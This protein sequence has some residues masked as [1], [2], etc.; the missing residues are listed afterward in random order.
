MATIVAVDDR[1]DDLRLLSLLLEAGGHDVSPA[2]SA[3]EALALIEEREPDL[4]VSDILMPEVDG[5]ELLGRLRGDERYSQLRVVFCSALYGDA[6]AVALAGDLGVSAMVTKPLDPATFASL[7]QTVLRSEPPSAAADTEVTRKRLSELN[8]L[9]Y[10]KLDAL[11]RS[12]QDLEES[13]LAEQRAVARAHQYSAVV[14]LGALALRQTPL[15]ELR[16]VAVE[17]VAEALDVALVRILELA[18]GGDS[19]SP[20]AAIG[21]SGDARYETIPVDSLVGRALSTRG[22][23]HITDLSGA[24]ETGEPAL[25]EG[26]VSGAICLLGAPERPLGL[27]SVFSTVPRRFSDDEMLFLQ[28]M[29][30]VVGDAY[31]RD[32]VA[33]ELAARVAELSDSEERRRRLLE[34]LAHAEEAERARVASDIHDDSAQVMTALILRLGLLQRRVSDPVISAE[35]ADVT[36][37]ASDSVRR[38]RHLLFELSPPALDGEEGVGGALRE[39]LEQL[40]QRSGVAFA[41]EAELSVQPDSAAGAVIYRIAQEALANVRKHA[42]ASRATVRLV[43]TESGIVTTV[44]DDGDGFDLDELVEAPGHVGL[45]S[46]RHRAE[47]AGGWLRIG[48]TLGKGTTVEYYVPTA[49]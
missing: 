39:Y 19:L 27:L 7:I 22:P 48:S 16:R 35:L 42:R 10:E 25:K 14:A 20:R 5:L 23:V 33:K 8:A 12:N 17:S 30:N 38:L 34:E 32:R 47:T 6:D 3:A 41:L 40:G 31:E 4:V 37:I 45:S 49:A 18:P 11:E 2:G 26:A 44:T 46:M 28:A 43:E 21:W 15:G 29:A 9:L 24:S 36:A 1:P 13:R